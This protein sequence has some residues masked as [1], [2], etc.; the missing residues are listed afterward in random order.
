MGAGAAAMSRA[1]RLSPARARAP[2]APPF[3]LHCGL[4][5]H[6]REQEVSR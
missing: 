3:D 6:P 5:I 1:T 4:L 2:P